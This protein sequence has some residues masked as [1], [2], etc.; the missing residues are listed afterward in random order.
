MGV[1]RPI[2]LNQV[3]SRLLRDY[4]LVGGLPEAVQRWVADASPVRVRE[5]QTDL[6]QALADDL[7]RYRGVRD[8][9]YLEAAFENMRFHFGTRFKYENFA[10]G[11]RSKQMKVALGKLEGAMIVTRVWPSSSLRLPLQV[12]PRSAPKLLPLDVGLAASMMATPIGLLQTQPIEQL[13][14]GRLAEIFVGQQ[15]LTARPGGL[16]SLHFWVTQSSRNNAEVDYLVAGQNGLIPVEVKAGASG[17]LKSLHQFL[18]RARVTTG[19]R[20]YTGPWSVLQNQVKI[21]G[22]LLDYRLASLPLYLAET[23]GAS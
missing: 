12:R 3:H 20:L 17:S 13:L 7:H 2:P 19:L 5:V 8:L 23:V 21:A 9:A 1:Q 10:P 11:Y 14:D 15:L 4:I 16:E 6:L 22:Q 18:L